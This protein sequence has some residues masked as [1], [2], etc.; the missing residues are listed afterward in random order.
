MF[1]A[2]YFPFGTL[3]SQWRELN[4]NC[5]QSTSAS[6]FSHYTDNF[7][8]TFVSFSCFTW[9]ICCWGGRIHDYRVAISAYFGPCLVISDFS[10]STLTVLIVC[11][12][13]YCI[14]VFVCFC[15]CGVHFFLCYFFSYF[16]DRHFL[17]D[18]SSCLAAPYPWSY[19]SKN[20]GPY[21]SMEK[22]PR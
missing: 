6:Q 22:V 1:R 4:E 10:N 9:L 14:H 11:A 19:I 15:P 5:A 21:S 7:S 12:W 3:Y 16:V 13:V 18:I 20:T 8:S 17:I 2:R